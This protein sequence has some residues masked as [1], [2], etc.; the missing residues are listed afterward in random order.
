LP[1]LCCEAR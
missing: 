1:A